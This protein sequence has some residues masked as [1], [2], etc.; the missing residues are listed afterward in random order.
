MLEDYNPSYRKDLRAFSALQPPPKQTQSNPIPNMRKKT[1]L[2][3][4][5]NQILPACNLKIC[6]HKTVKVSR[7]YAEN[8]A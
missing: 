7:K 1:K 6:F 3:K 5:P 4:T 8:I 2:S